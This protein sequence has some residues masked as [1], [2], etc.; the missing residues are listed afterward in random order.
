[1]NRARIQ[2]I[3]AAFDLP[4]F[5]TRQLG[6]AIFREAIDA[7]AA[8]TTLP[9]ALRPQL[10]AAEPILSVTPLEVR[11]ADDG[12]AHKALVELSDGAAVETV[13]LQ[14]KPD[15]WSC[16][17][18]SQ[19]GCAYN[20]SFC[21]TGAMG[22]VRDLT[23]EEISDQVLFWRGYIRRQG[24][25]AELRN[26]VYMG[27]G[28]PFA[29]TDAVLDSLAELTAEDAFNIGARH[30][31]VST[32]GIPEGIAA[33]TCRFPQV[34]L[35]ISLH[36]A[37]DRLRSNLVPA[38]RKHP[39]A[40]IGTAIDRHLDATNRKVFLEV[41]L[42]DRRNDGPRDAAA[43][44]DFI[45]ARTR[46]NLLHVNLIACNP[47]DVS[48]DRPSPPEAIRRFRAMLDRRGIHHTV[49]KSLGAD[50]AGACGQL[51][52]SSRRSPRPQA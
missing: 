42:L 5:R 39:L 6:Q 18:S 50:I 29:N 23:A 24:L 32:V 41:I 16:C 2:A 33:L 10:A 28:E 22:L 7:Y 11:V 43:L 51:A 17:I 13:L 45:D 25:D 14:P 40:R 12:C 38:N 1:M 52:T 9:A 19:V 49:R 36:A 20:C 47:T 34:N 21:A 37:N 30:I 8:I 44:A 4:A 46:P 35:A 26:V 3:A 27:M 48:G 15:L 31:S